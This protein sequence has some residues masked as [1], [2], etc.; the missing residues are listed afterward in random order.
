MMNE[1]WRNFN[2][3]DDIKGLTDKEQIQYW[4]YSYHKAYTMFEDC[5][6]NTLEQV[7]FYR[8]LVKEFRIKLQ[9]AREH[10]NNQ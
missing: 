8:Q 3:I 5:A 9:A 2:E 1:P 6:E 10:V 4:K 7:S